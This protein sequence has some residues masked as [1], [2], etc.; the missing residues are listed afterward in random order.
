MRSP[1]QEVRE[2]IRRDMYVKFFGEKHVGKR[3]V[4]AFV[5]N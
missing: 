2:I 3:D 1:E 5:Y 4:D